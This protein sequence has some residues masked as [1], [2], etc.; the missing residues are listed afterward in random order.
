M[1]S[2]ERLQATS[3]GPMVCWLDP[4]SAAVQELYTLD[5]R[6]QDANPLTINPLEDFSEFQRMLERAKQLDGDTVCLRDPQENGVIGYITFSIES[7]VSPAG[8]GLSYVDFFQS[9]SGPSLGNVLIID[10]LIVNPDHQGKGYGSTLMKIA[11]Q[12]S[13]ERGCSGGVALLASPYGA[14]KFYKNLGY[15]SLLIFPM[16]YNFGRRSEV[17]EIAMLPA[18]TPATPSFNN[19][20]YDIVPNHPPIHK[21]EARLILYK[22]ADTIEAQLAGRI[23]AGGAEAS[24]QRLNGKLS[25]LWDDDMDEENLGR[26]RIIQMAWEGM[27]EHYLKQLM[28]ET[29]RNESSLVSNIAPELFLCGLLSRPSDRVSEAPSICGKHAYLAGI[30]SLSP[31]VIAEILLDAWNVL[32]PDEQEQA[33]RLH[34]Q[35]REEMSQWCA[36][37]MSGFT[38]RDST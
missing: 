2:G 17:R 3:E 16:S 13:I 34:K 5:K 12:A 37:F 26:I 10:S 36:G 14:E 31:E 29:D 4:Y 6:V 25:E 27:A 35:L 21:S 33:E 11:E 30:F 19:E 8:V 18:A 23:S 15:S 20:D 1:L 28:P 7:G 9:N 22:S 38:A 32:S 24:R